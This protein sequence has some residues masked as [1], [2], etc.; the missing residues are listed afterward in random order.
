[1]KPCLI[2]L[3]IA[4]PLAS[5]AKGEEPDDR[6]CLNAPSLV[7]QGDWGACIH[8]WAYRLAGS[9]D[10]AKIV[11]EATVAACADAIAWQVNNADVSEYGPNP[12]ARRELNDRIM[13]SAPDLALY[14]VVQSRA[15]HCEIP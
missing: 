15:G 3:L 7:A 6:I 8:K 11:A 4:F 5:C 14:H 2:A 13:A 10:P 1:M 12:E 9:P